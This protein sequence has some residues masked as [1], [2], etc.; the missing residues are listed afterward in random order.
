M[1]PCDGGRR[2]AVMAPYDGGLWLDMALHGGNM[3]R[4]GARLWRSNGAIWREAMALMAPH[5]GA[6]AG[7]YGAGRWRAMG[8]RWLIMAIH[9]G[10]Y[11]DM[12]WAMMVFLGV[13]IMAE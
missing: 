3:A 1:A 2:R 11:G 5:H 10:P 7:Q 4:R 9:G 13:P 6:M 8:V 12:R